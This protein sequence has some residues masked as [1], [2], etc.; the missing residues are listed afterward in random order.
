MIPTMI[1]AH[2]R[3]HH[4]GCEHLTH[5]PVMT[6]QDLAAAE[7]VSGR[8]VAKPVVV[9]LDGQLAVAV[10]AATEKVNLAALEEALGVPAELAT[11]QE[12]AP[13]F[14]PCEPGAEP[15]LAIFGMPLFV[16]QKL[17]TEKT[18][19]MAA[20]SHEDAIVLDTHEWLACEKPQPIANLGVRVH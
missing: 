1:Q 12:F 8:H 5:A 6:A 19:V 15:P 13:R 11:E 9:K 2:L 14:Q 4:Q 16:D 20:G 3:L 18:L 10:V 17:E 7:H